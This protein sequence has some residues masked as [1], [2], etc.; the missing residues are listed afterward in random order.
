MKS[1]T[2]TCRVYKQSNSY[3][4]IRTR[5]LKLRSRFLHKQHRVLQI[6][7]LI[8]AFRPLHLLSI[9]EI[10]RRV[11]AGLSTVWVHRQCFTVPKVTPCL[12]CDTGCTYDYVRL[13][14]QIRGAL[15]KVYVRFYDVDKNFIFMKQKI[16]VTGFWT[17]KVC[18]CF[19]IL[20][21]LTVLFLASFT[22][23]NYDYMNMLTGFAQG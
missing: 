18:D 12:R 19:T 20:V 6:L 3:F 13:A 17:K 16:F 2:Q 1:T 14:R 23:C 7:Y 11:L 8:K 22:K 9:I 4:F 5:S 15:T 21:Q 10:T